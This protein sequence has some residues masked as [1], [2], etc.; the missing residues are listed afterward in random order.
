MKHEPDTELET[1]VPTDLLGF[2]RMARANPKMRFT[3]LLGMVWRKEG[4]LA[5]F[6]RQPGGKAPGVDG[7]GKKE[8]QE[9][10]E[11]RLGD[12]SA[13]LRRLA[14]R[15]K[16]SRR[17]MIPKMDGRYRPLGIPSF[18]DRIVQDRMSSIM[19]AIWEPEFWDCSYGFRPGRS[20]HD[21]L[22]QVA[23]VI[24][25]E[26]TQWVVEVDIKGFFDN[27][28]HEILMKFVGHRIAD[29]GFLRL[30]RRFLKAGAVEDGIYS[31]TTQ[32]TPQ[33]GLV[34]PVLANIYLH[35]VLDWWFEC[36]FSKSCRKGAHLI[37]YA[38]DFIGCFH[39]EQDAN[40]FVVELRTRLAEFG[41]EVSEEKT[42]IHRFGSQGLNDKG[43]RP[44]IFNFL[45]FT[46]Y[47][48]KSRSGRFMVGRRTERKRFSKKL[49]E[50]KMKLRLLRLAGGRAMIDYARQHLRGHIQYYGVSG[51]FPM[52]HMY[53]YRVGLCLMKWLNRRS[54]KR[55]M[56]WD[57]YSKLLRSGLLPTARIVHNL[58]PKPAWMT[59]A[60]SRVR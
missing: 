36:R 53:V 8:Y 25:N 3:S 46:H 5:S 7:I 55:S 21:A 14:Y 15:P 32:G 58:Y 16:P 49:K 12:L 18:E 33:G 59:Q 24:T 48:T 57:K 47:V 26:R 17:V 27:V 19:Q 37:R 29:P 30:I 38:D 22:R 23:K 43:A 10:F 41:L 42:A 40:R 1:H 13:R 4:L 11:D 2:T 28:D 45:G 51:N 20:A 54:Q 50:V 31:A 56:T 39:N 52:L 35:Y 44:S 9:G 34:S 60:G 6:K